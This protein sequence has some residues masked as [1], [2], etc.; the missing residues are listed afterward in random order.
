[1]L[2]SMFDWVIGNCR[3][4][5]GSHSQDGRYGFV[6]ITGDRIATISETHP[7]TA[8]REI[9][10]HGLVL[11]P[12]FIDVHTHDDLA[13]IQK[14]EMLPK[15]SQGVTTVIAGN[16]GISASPA[17]LRN[18]HLPDPMNLLGAAET[19]IYSDFQSYAKAVSKARP[20]VNIASLA[21]HTTLRNNAMTDLSRP[22]NV[23]ELHQMIQH[24]DEAMAQGAIG[25]STGL[26]YANA[27]QAPASEIQ[28]LLEV[29]ARYSGIYTTHLRNEFE[30]ILEAMD[31]AIEVARSTGVPLVISHHKVAG[32][33]NWG[34]TTQTIEKLQQASDQHEIACDC[35][36][37]SAS[38]STLDLGQVT[39]D[40]KIFI[41]WSDPMPEHAGKYLQDIANEIGVSLLEAAE[42]LM[43]AGA[44][45]H[46]MDP[47]D[48]ERV[49]KWKFT[50]IGSDGL[51][52][53]PFPHPRLHGTFPRV[54]GR[55]R[56]ERNLF[57]LT[58]AVH[59][60]TGLA[61]TRFRLNERGFIRTG[62]FADLVL[63]DEQR[64]IDR[65]DFESPRL[66]SEGIS[67]VWVNGGLAWSGEDF[68]VHL[69]STGR[70]GRM[71]IRKD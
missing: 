63:F 58:T 8:A 18:N 5:E 38:S 31:E 11:A 15:I 59:K 55:L 40:I 1:M 57:D 49:L 67:A 22:A 21:G 52:C 46:C 71:L 28:R 68:P 43:P 36:P 27:R 42:K 61:A 39:P 65:A 13:V 16:C 14:P 47:E 56:R 30:S 6:A 4:L 41:S 17:T 29:V 35:Y 62:Y 3:I 12:G 54:I 25:L 45:Y 50:M 9:D 20:A 48:V 44:I 53:D 32:R 23:S 2:G 66:L 70:F 24:L 10:G 51:P 34:R 33:K 7:G 60:A 19:F 69:K 26:A 37:Y 64:L